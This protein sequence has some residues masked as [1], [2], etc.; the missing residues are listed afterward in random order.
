MAKYEKLNSLFAD[1][2]NTNSTPVNLNALIQ[3][4]DNLQTANAI[5]CFEERDYLMNFIFFYI[6]L[7]WLRSSFV[8]TQEVIYHK[9]N[10]RI[11]N[12]AQPLQQLRRAPSVPPRSIA[13]EVIDPNLANSATL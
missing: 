6:F 1:D 8:Y 9:P 13:A 12:A 7:L 2:K 11:Y 5:F 4:L 3:Q 10:S